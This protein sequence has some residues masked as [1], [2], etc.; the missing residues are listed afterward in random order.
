MGF[1][2]TFDKPLTYIQSLVR[3]YSW[4]LGKFS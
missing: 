2:E 4:V 3:K 1:N